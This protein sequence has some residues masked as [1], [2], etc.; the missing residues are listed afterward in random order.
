MFRFVWHMP[1]NA[2]IFLIKVYQRTLSPDHGI[3]RRLWPHGYCKFDPTCSSYARI[4]IGKYGVVR[5]VPKAVW[6]IL[7]CNPCGKGGVDLPG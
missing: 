7:R 6:R 4:V 3:F 5:G 1:R 2:V